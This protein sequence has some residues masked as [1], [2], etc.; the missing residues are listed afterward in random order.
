MENWQ[1]H[2]DIKSG[3]GTITFITLVY[4]KEHEAFMIT[5]VNA[6]LCTGN[7]LALCGSRIAGNTGSFHSL[8]STLVLNTD[9]G[10]SL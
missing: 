10:P 7:A 8:P 3:F 9:L 1:N 5:R 4:D 6:L 2:R